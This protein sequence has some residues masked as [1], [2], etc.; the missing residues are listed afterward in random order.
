VAA[1]GRGAF[2]S[3]TISVLR[4]RFNVQPRTVAPGGRIT[5]PG[6]F[7]LPGSFVAIKLDGRVIAATRTNEKGR[8]SKSV[9]IPSTTTQRA[10]RI[11]SR[12]HGRIVGSQSQLIDAVVAY[13]TQQSLL[14][15]DRTAVAAGQTVSVCG[16]KCPT[17]QPMASVDGQPVDLNLNRRV[18]GAGFTATATIPATV[19][20]GTHT[21]RAG[22][23]AGLVRDHPA[24]G[25]A[26]RHPPGL[27]RPP[28]SE[29]AIWLGL[30][31]GLALLVASVGFTT[32][33]RS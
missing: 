6:G 5:V 2:R 26:G 13:P 9:T 12:C 16:T 7:C 10:H 22:C 11:G 8:F 33:R 21:L 24:A 3:V 4:S 18:T 17:G 20:P 19:T 30:F 27:R 32:R 1:F 29:L 23:D 15:T 28:P 14:T 31:T 25:P